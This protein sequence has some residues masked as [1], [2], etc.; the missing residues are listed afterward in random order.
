MTLLNLTT[1]NVASTP[2]ST[3]AKGKQQEQKIPFTMIHLGAVKGYSC[4]GCGSHIRIIPNIPEPPFDY[5]IMYFEKREWQRAGGP[6]CISPKCV[7]TYYHFDANC[8][9]RKHPSFSGAD[10][11]ISPETAQNLLPC[12]INHL[13]E[14]FGLEPSK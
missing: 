6:P 8:I 11:S 4:Y 1:T 5:C 7:Y 10:L 14:R 9:R 3:S 2:K 13:R 12:H